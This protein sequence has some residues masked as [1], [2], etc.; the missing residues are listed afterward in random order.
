[1]DKDLFLRYFN[2]PPGPL[3]SRLEN[4]LVKENY[5]LV[6]KLVDKLLFYSDVHIDKEDAYQ[7]GLIGLMTALRRFDPNRGTKLSTYAAWWIRLEIGKALLHETPIYRPRAAGIP[8]QIK[9]L[10]DDIEGR[11]GIPATA[12][13]LGLTEAQLEKYLSVAFHYM[14]LDADDNETL[15]RR[16]RAIPDDQSL[17]EEQ[18]HDAQL[19]DALK[20]ILA[21]L[22]EE[23]RRVIL[24]ND[25]KVEDY[26]EIRQRVI[27]WGKE[28]L[29]GF[30]Q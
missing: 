16:V 15:R 19:G 13:Q 4:Q 17:P 27:A 23:E 8:W 30:T 25:K 21:E 6:N 18:I 5:F 12:E 24:D 22:T 29:R 7:F 14:P 3:K 20:G 9:K 28:A 2:A 26:E 11:T 10:Q 1:M